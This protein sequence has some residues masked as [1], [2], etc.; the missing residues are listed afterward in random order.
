MVLLTGSKRGPLVSG[1]WAEDMMYGVVTERSQRWI[2]VA[3]DTG[4]DKEDL[5]VCDTWRYGQLLDI[6]IDMY[7]FGYADAHEHS[8]DELNSWKRTVAA[9]SA[10]TFNGTLAAVTCIP[11]LLHCCMQGYML[12]AVASVYAFHL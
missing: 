1:D 3:F 9:C 2:K 7:L 4:P 5:Q 8:A 10:V 11:T 12:I 6:H